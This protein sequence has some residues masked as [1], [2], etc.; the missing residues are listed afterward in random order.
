MKLTTGLWKTTSKNG[1]NYYKGS[2][3]LEDGRIFNVALFNNADK[4]TSEKSPDLSL[5]IEERQIT[6][7]TQTNE[8]PKVEEKKEDYDPYAEFGKKIEIA[9]EDL[10][11]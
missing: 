3:K 6:E 1:L 2:I 11:F 7:Q 8:Q 9:D 4:K 5:S 10:P